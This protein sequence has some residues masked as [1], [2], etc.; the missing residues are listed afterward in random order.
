LRNHPEHAPASRTPDSGDLPGGDEHLAIIEAVLENTVDGIVT[1]DESGTILLFNPAAEKI[2]GYKAREVIGQGVNLLMPGPSSEDH[3]KYLRRYMDTGQARVIGIGREVTGRRRNGRA[4][5]LEL[6][7]SEL[8]VGDRRLFTGILRDITARKEAERALQE[9]RNFVSAILNT[10]GALIVVLNADGRVVRFNRTCEQLTGFRDDEITGCVFWETLVPTEEEGPFRKAFEDMV[11]G[12]PPVDMDSILH[13]RQGDRRRIAWSHSVLTAEN[14]RVEYVIGC[15]LDI[16]DKKAAEEA[17]VSL[18][19]A[20]RRQVGQELHDALG[21]VM[22]GVTLLTSA[23]ERKLRER[24]LPEQREAGEITRL[25]KTAL[26]QVKRLAHG[27]YPTE[28]ERHGLSAALKELAESQQKLHGIRCIYQGIERISHLDRPAELH[29]YRIAQEAVNNAVKHG[30]AAEIGVTY[31][32]DDTLLKLTV[33]D[34]GIG[35][36]DPPPQGSGMGLAIMRYRAAQIDA[37]MHIARRRSGG[38]RVE[39]VQQRGSA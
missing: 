19:E 8:K 22:T 16:T 33:E 39:C 20:E 29:L 38:T 3:V 4:F 11:A 30:Q 36:P 18:S 27:L 17:L 34:N 25:A 2:F 10:V 21:Q 7:V 24:N 13:T 14:G 12:R 5:P 9:E 23:L 1:I 32:Y 15:G 35:I 6:S 31:F 26:S 37:E 28:L